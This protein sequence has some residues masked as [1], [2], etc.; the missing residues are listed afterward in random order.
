MAT[1]PVVSIV[2]HAVPPQ[3]LASASVGAIPRH[4]LQTG[5][6]AVAVLIIPVRGDNEKS[7][8]TKSLPPPLDPR[9]SFRYSVKV[10]VE[11]AVHIAVR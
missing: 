9:I 1:E 10:P 11:G 6:V 8:R 3:T 5:V 2:K 7:S 4:G